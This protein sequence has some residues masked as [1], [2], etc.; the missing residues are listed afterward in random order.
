M[1]ERQF[2]DPIYDGDFA[3]LYGLPPDTKIIGPPMSGTLLTKTPD[4]SSPMLKYDGPWPPPKKEAAKPVEQTRPTAAVPPPPELIPDDSSA[5]AI[6]LS[7]DVCKSPTA[8]VPYMVWGKADDKQNYSPDVRSNGDVIKRSDSRFTATYGDQPGTGLGVK[9]GTVGNVVTPV[10]SS[11]IVRANGV[12]VQRHTDRCT[13][14]NGNCP[15]EYVNVK[16]TAMDMPPDGNDAQDRSW[17][18]AAKDTGGDFW[19]GMT[20]TSGTASSGEGIFNKVGEWWNDPSQIGRDAQSAY[21]SI[22]TGSEIWQGTKN[23]AGGAAHVAGEVWNDP[24][25]SA[26]ATG[27]W[28]K[29]QAVG[30]WHGVEAG[31]EKHGVAGAVGAVAGIAVEIVN[32]LKKLKMLERAAEVAEELGDLKKAE[33]LRKEAEE[34]REKEK[35]AERAREAKEEGKDG[36]RSTRIH[37]VDCFEAPPGIDLA[38]YDRQLDE[39]MKTINDMTADDMAYSHWVLD[40]AGGTD[41]LR[42]PYAQTQHRNEYKQMLKD[43]GWSDVDIKN[44]MQGLHATHFLDMV[45]GGNPTVFSRDAAGNPILGAGDVNSH[46]G[47]SWTQKGRAASLGEEAERMRRSGRAAEKMHVELKRCK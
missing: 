20:A 21:D 10:T 4:G 16:S 36:A 30:A 6:C 29:D 14:N 27:G 34:I 17:W 33:K 19:K 35:Q 31:Y 8:P 37:H 42:Q 18:D 38:E 11:N 13:L 28:A 39:Q 43:K 2:P 47:S 5:I 46:I 24:V 25:G 41:A 44:H 7:P 3:A 1:G 12:P 23:I 32:P 9:S 22:P 45:A 26:K 40:K 15:G